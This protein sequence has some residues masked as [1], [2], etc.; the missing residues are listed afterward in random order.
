MQVTVQKLSPVLV[1]F[2]VQVAADRVKRELDKAYISVSKSA[3]VRGFRPGKAPRR[4]LA[5]NASWTRRS[6]RP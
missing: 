3:R 6:R 2:D 5:Y 1:E 4:V